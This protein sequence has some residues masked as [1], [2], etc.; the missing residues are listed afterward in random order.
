MI[1][2]TFAAF[3]YAGKGNKSQYFMYSSCLKLPFVENNL[4]NKSLKTP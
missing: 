1:E 4:I 2:S 3:I